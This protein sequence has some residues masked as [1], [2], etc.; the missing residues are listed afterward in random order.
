[1]T[2]EEL[3]DNYEFKVTKRTLMNE[4]PFIKDVYAEDEE[5]INRYEHYIWLSVDIDPY[6]M[7]QMYGLKV[8]NFVTNA[9]KRGEPYWA[10]YLSTLMVGSVDDTW[11]IRQALEKVIDGVHKSPALP[12]E[13]KLPK[14]LDIASYN[15]KPEY[16]PPDITS[17]Y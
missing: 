13:L 8:V 16:L 15:V 1:M 11:P 10:P 5:A 17:S 6:Q 7:G 3:Y 9:L 12:S 14:E 2:K 4:F